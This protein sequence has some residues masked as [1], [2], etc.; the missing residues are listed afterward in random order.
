MNKLQW[1]AGD[2]YNEDQ[3]EHL[4]AIRNGHRYSIEKEEIT[5]GRVWRWTPIVRPSFGGEIPADNH[6][7]FLRDAKRLLET[8]F[9]AEIERL[10]Q[11][12]EA[13]P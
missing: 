9:E 13:Q 8:D 4:Y 2:A 6:C 12:H 10:R 7:F 1:H 5:K 3:G 11:E